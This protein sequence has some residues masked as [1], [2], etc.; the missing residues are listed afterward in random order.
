M[1]LSPEKAGVDQGNA[2]RGHVGLFIVA[3]LTLFVVCI[4]FR[5]WINVN[6]AMDKFFQSSDRSTASGAGRTLHR[7]AHSGM[8]STA[9]AWCQKRMT[10]HSRTRTVHT[11]SQVM[12]Q[13]TQVRKPVE[14]LH[15]APEKHN[16]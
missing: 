16:T 7:I 9:P 10:P 4:R 5:L 3:I 1:A 12:P 2:G 14:L 15:Q 11:N 8:Q 13:T 6:A